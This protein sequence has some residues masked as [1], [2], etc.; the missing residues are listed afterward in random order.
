[1]DFILFTTQNIDCISEEIST[2]CRINGEVNNYTCSEKSY[3]AFLMTCLAQGTN[4]PMFTQLFW[5]PIAH[6]GNTTCM[7]ISI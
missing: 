4:Q 7:F 2:S 5:H 3:G 1:M 6:Y